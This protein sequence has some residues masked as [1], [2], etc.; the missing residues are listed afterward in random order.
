MLSS[1]LPPPPHLVP[2]PLFLSPCVRGL[3]RLPALKSLES[4]SLRHC[5]GLGGEA[6]LCLSNSPSLEMLSLAHC[7]LLDDAAVRNLAGLSKLSSLEL[8]G[9]EVRPTSPFRLLRTSIRPENSA[10]FSIFFFV[11]KKKTGVKYLIVTKKFQPTCGV[12]AISSLFFPSLRARSSFYSSVFMFFH[13]V[14][15]CPCYHR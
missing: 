4:A 3:S 13:F 12:H 8:E 7:P 1:L 2:S 15:F 9:C 5:K 14:Y 10:I 11:K 6:T